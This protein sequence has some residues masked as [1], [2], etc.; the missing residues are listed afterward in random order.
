MSLQAG[1]V[2]DSNPTMTVSEVE[3]VHLFL[4]ELFLSLVDTI[5]LSL[6]LRLSLRSVS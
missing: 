6:F 2:P 4:S 5:L 3:L 1:E